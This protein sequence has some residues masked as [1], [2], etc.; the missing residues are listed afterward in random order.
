M[1]VEELLYGKIP[2]KARGMGYRETSSGVSLGCGR[3][4]CSVYGEWLLRRVRSG[5]S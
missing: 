1:N 5:R 2:W 3:F 4:G